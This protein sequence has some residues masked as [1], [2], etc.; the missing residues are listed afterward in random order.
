MSG[1]YRWHW[2]IG[3]SADGLMLG[4]LSLP[5][6]SGMQINWGFQRGSFPGLVATRFGPSLVGQ[7]HLKFAGFDFYSAKRIWLT[8]SGVPMTWA[9]QYDIREFTIGWW[10]VVGCSGLLPLAWTW[11]EVKRW[12]RIRRERRI[13]GKLC[14][15]CGY[16][17]RATPGRC[18]E[19]GSLREETNIDGTIVA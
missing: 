17:L 13:A 10:L 5:E 9:G 7:R 1:R 19:C 3:S 8:N 15:K 16:D 6:N 4:D 14:L 11:R 18:P 12:R 2:W